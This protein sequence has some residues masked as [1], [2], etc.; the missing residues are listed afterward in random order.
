MAAATI[1]NT[2]Y[3]YLATTGTDATSVTTNKV[4]LN[5]IEVMGTAGSET[6]IVTDT[7]GNAIFKTVLAANVSQLF[8]YGG[9]RVEG[10][11]VTLSADTVRA[12]FFIG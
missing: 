4:R 9:A 11:K 2:S 5:S 7:A 12:N 8:D 1:K 3:G 6:V 10:L